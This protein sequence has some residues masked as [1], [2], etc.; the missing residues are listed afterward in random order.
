MIV[1]SLSKFVTKFKDSQIYSSIWHINNF[2]T[3]ER[4]FSSTGQELQAEERQEKE[5]AKEEEKHK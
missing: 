4:M 2:R 3:V 1:D 5:E